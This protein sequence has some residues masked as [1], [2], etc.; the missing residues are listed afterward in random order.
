MTS[1]SS[2]Q[3][4]IIGRGIAGLTLAARLVDRGVK[5]IIFG[6]SRGPA[7]AS[8]CAQGVLANKGLIFAESP[9]FRAKLRSLRH[10]Q[11]WLEELER[12]TGRTIPRAFSGVIEPYWSPEDFQEIATR[13]YRRTFTGCYLTHHLAAL[14]RSS[15]LF[16]EK[17]PLG[18]L[19]YPLNGWFDVPATL[20][21]LEDKCRRSGA[22]IRETRV[23]ALEAKG[24]SLRVICSNEGRYV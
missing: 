19:R 5:P 21:A 13:V 18:V 1:L 16:Q 22:T 24:V 15:P 14:D 8:R 20:D 7:N 17:K 23:S 6:S 4:A 11:S 9:L 2:L 3:I 12:S 10:T